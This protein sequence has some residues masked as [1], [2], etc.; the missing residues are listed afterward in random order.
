[1]YGA[2]LLDCVGACFV[3]SYYRYTNSYFPSG[4]T[5]KTH[6]FTVTSSDTRIRVS[7]AFN[8]R[9]VGSG[10]NHSSIDS[11]DNTDLNIQV[12]DPNGIIVGFSTTKNNNVEIVDFVPATTG[13]YTVVITRADNSSETVY[14]GLAWR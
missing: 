1:M 5:S 8:K 4:T 12:K 3:T 9:S 7:L 14:Y 6:T 10:T 2:G 13:T 11:G